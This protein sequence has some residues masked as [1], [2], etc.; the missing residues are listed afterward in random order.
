M[1]GTEL[2]LENYGVYGLLPP[3]TIWLSL[4][5]AFT[6]RDS[7]KLF[8][9]PPLTYLAVQQT[10]V[11]LRKAIRQAH[12]KNKIVNVFA[13]EARKN[14]ASTSAE[15]KVKKSGFMRNLDD[16][17]GNANPEDGKWFSMHTTVQVENPETGVYVT[18][19]FIDPLAKDDWGFLFSYTHRL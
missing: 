14:G 2:S 4:L 9:F 3:V 12:S 19:Y 5:S 17:L 15:D 7:S 13:E 10:I 6:L 18:Q 1:E 11:P 8:V 16:V